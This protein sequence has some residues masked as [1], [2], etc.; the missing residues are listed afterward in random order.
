MH[1][2][3]LIRAEIMAIQNIARFDLPRRVAAVDINANFLLRAAAL[4]A[5]FSVTC[6]MKM[7]I[8]KPQG[9]GVFPQSA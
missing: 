4:K 9:G 1:Q 7:Y 2:R 6:V 8:T 5:Q 3:G